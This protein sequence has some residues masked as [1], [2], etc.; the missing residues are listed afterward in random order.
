MQNIVV[1]RYNTELRH[2]WQ[3][4]IEP[5]DRSWIAFIRNDG[6][7]IFFLNRDPKS[8]AVLPDDPKEAKAKTKLLREAEKTPRKRKAQ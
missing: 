4:W 5:E 8:G 1:R 3:G 2:L 7:P 6:I